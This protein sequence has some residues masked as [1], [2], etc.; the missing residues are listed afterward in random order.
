MEASPGALRTRRGF[1]PFFRARKEECLVP[2]LRHKPLLVFRV[3]DI[4]F[5]NRSSN[6]AFLGSRLYNSKKGIGP[7]P[8]AENTPA[9][10]CVLVRHFSSCHS[11]AFPQPGLPLADFF[12]FSC[13]SPFKNRSI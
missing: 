12:G 6:R 11:L 4:K 5:L 8:I 1:A 9:R 13:G 7:A 3:G 10:Q 2:P